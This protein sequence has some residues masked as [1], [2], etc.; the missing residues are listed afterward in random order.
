[1]NIIYTIKGISKLTFLL[2]QPINPLTLHLPKL[3]CL[4]K[5]KD[6]PMKEQISLN[7]NLHK[8]VHKLHKKKGI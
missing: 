2:K 8:N 1:M 3:L 6:C 5:L 7:A 4:F